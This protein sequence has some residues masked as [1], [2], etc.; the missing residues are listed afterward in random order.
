MNIIFG[1]LLHLFCCGGGM[2]LA[3]YFLH[4]QTDRPL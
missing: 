3:L 2:L 4:K 1:F